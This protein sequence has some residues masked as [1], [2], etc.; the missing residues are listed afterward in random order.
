MA[1]DGLK[2]ALFDDGNSEDY[3]GLANPTNTYTADII[4]PPNSSGFPTKHL[5]ISNIAQNHIETTPDEAHCML[6]QGFC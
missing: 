3:S 2:K 4:F 1:F 6:H 5:S